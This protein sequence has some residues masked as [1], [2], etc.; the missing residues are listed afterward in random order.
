MRNIYFT[1]RHVRTKCVHVG[2]SQLQVVLTQPSIAS[3]EVQVRRGLCTL[4][5]EC[6]SLEVCGMGGGGH[7][8]TGDCVKAEAEVRG[9][10]QAPV[11]MQCAV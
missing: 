11:R 4:G 10:G 6:E 3:I 7:C 1:H 9:G 5:G 8:T 2:H